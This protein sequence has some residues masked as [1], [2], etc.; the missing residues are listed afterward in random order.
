MPLPTIW[1]TDYLEVPLWDRRPRRARQC[2]LSFRRLTVSEAEA[3]GVLRQILRGAEE[4]RAE[5]ELDAR[6]VA[7]YLAGR[8]VAVDGVRVTEPASELADWLETM[9]Y[10]G[11]LGNLLARVVVGEMLPD[12]TAP[13]SD[14]PSVTPSRSERAAVPTA[15]TSGNGSAPTALATPST[16]PGD[17]ASAR[18]TTPDG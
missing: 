18:S 5:L 7:E 17:R 2:L 11:A 1:E 8:L 12:P 14:G 4:G 15:V 9:G 10:Q 6:A 13:A 16:T 3:D